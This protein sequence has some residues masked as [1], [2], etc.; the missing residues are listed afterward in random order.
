VGFVTASTSVSAGPILFLGA[1]VIFLA[2]MGFAI[3][4]TTRRKKR[5]TE[6][7][8]QRAALASAESALLYWQ[9]AE[10]HLQAVQGAATTS[11]AADDG[12]SEGLAKA[13]EGRATAEKFRDQCQLDLINC[14]GGSSAIVP[15]TPRLLEPRRPA[16]NDADASPPTE[17]PQG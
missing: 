11:S 2:I 17:P 3:L 10:A 9:K 5:P 4:T 1:A 16:A 15:S 8:E 6:C 7:A 13:L 12:S 14:M